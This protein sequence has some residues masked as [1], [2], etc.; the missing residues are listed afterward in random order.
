MLKNRTFRETSL[1]VCLALV[2]LIAVGCRQKT[3]VS[4]DPNAPLYH[5]QGV[6]F[7]SY[8]T[9]IVNIITNS[10]SLTGRRLGDVNATNDDHRSLISKD[11]YIDEINSSATSSLYSW[12][13]RS[14]Y[15]KEIKDN[16][17]NIS[18]KAVIIKANIS[19]NWHTNDDVNA[20]TSTQNIGVVRVKKTKDKILLGERTGDVSIT[21]EVFDKD[22]NRLIAKLDISHDRIS[23][24][25]DRV[26]G[27]G[28]T[29]RVHEKLEK[30]NKVFVGSVLGLRAAQAEV[31]VRPNL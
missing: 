22:T 5:A 4:Q 14:G 1:T 17:D 15:F 16:A 10:A 30:W 31:S 21:Y 13:S 3:Y 6:D 24:Q 23:G 29:Q 9:A 20:E 25:G 2:T 26:W 18:G 7:N 11:V 27:D 12:L 19:V 8:D 28:A